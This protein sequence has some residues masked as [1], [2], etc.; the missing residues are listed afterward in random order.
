MTN[1][2]G[3]PPLPTR[4]IKAMDGMAV[5]ADVWEEAHQYHYQHQTLHARYGHG[6]GV[7][8]GL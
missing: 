7:L 3:L 1:S 4:R 2:N 5:T 8:G 6:A